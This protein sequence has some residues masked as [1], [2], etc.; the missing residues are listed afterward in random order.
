M[1]DRLSRGDDELKTGQL[2]RHESLI[3]SKFD[4]RIEATTTVGEYEAVIPSIAGRVW[5]TSFNQ[6]V[7]D[8]TDPFQEGFVVG[9]PWE[10][11]G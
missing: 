6:L 7:L 2:F 10:L 8:P 4:A 3:G 9:K 11:Y 1:L 5:I